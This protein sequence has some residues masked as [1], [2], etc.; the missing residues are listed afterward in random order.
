MITTPTPADYPRLTAIWEDAVRATHHFLSEADIAYFKPLVLEQYLPAVPLAMLVADGAIAGFAGVLDG[1]IEM[2]FVDPK[3]HGRGI[4]K[5]L[6]AH[7]IAQ[8]AAGA[9][10]VNEQN[11][12]ACGF[13]EKLGFT[14]H[15]RSP[16]DGMGKPFP[17]LHLRL[18]H[19]GEAR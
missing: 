8:M 5:R 10:D 3:L 17:L 16:L 2:L 1:K 11:P 19:A 4:G 9:V 18:A 13:Y 7:A 6:V 12:Q 15:A 14:V